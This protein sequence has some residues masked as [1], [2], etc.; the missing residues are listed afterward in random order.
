MAIPNYLEKH[1]KEREKLKKEM[2]MM[3]GMTDELKEKIEEME[4]VN[5][6]NRKMVDTASLKQQ[7][8]KAREESYI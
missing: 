8:A 1:F 4:A 5:T 3:G 6:A 2:K 7:R